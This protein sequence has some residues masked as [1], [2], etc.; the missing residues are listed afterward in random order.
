MHSEP[1]VF[2]TSSS[3]QIQP[4]SDG[5]EAL[6]T[7][8]EQSSAMQNASFD[9]QKLTSEALGKALQKETHELTH[10]SNTVSDNVSLHFQK[11]ES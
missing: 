10:R 1:P 5:G 7:V 11:Y 6:S 9:L 8:I 2:F 4:S 3:S